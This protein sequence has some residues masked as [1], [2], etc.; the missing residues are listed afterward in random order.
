MSD[1][2]DNTYVLAFSMMMLH[3]DAFNKHNKNKMTKSD[4]VRN[5]R[6]DGV[7]PI[8]LEAFFDNITFTPFVFIEDDADL[9]RASG[10]ESATS[11]LGSSPLASGLSTPGLGMGTTSKSSKID[12]YHMIVRGLLPTLRVD[13][14]SHIAAESPFSCL[15]TRPFLDMDGLHRAFVTARSL[16]IDA[17]SH[18]KKGSAVL[19]DKLSA[20][21]GDTAAAD[22]EMVLKITKVGLLSRKGTTSRF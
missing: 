17:P 22:G 10:H 8:V 21:K 3:T 18:K 19:S 2:S 20:S 5:T 15:G 6:L 9:R 13:V 16:H 1:L 14:E 7:P 4:Y 11:Q 12:V